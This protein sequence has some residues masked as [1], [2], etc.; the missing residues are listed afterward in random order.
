MLIPLYQAASSMVILAL[1]ASSGR[2]ILQTRRVMTQDQVDGDCSNKVTRLINTFEG[3]SRLPTDDIVNQLKSMNR[4]ELLQVFKN[5]QAPTSISDIEGAWDGVLLENN[6]FVMTTISSILT[7]IFFS[8]GRRWNGK[9][10]HADGHGINRFIGKQDGADE[11]GTRPTTAPPTTLETEHSFQYSIASSS[12]DKNSSAVKLVY[13]KFQSSWS[14][15]KTMVDEV[16]LVPAS[17]GGV[18]LGLGSMAWSGGMLNSTPFC[19][20]RRKIEQQVSYVE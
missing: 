8:M 11:F 1:A 7:N 13:A 16:R 17:N 3:P 2:N 19:L 4:M 10:F 20:W 6:G 15:W 5:S 14:L 9:A 18:L 12:V